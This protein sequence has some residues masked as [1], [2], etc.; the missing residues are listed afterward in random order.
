[1]QPLYQR[2]PPNI[3]DA[4]VSWIAPATQNASLQILFKRPTSAIVFATA[5]KPSRFAYLRQGAESIGLATETTLE[6]PKVVRTYGT[7]SFFTSKCAAPPQR[8]ACFRHLNFQ[9]RSERLVFQH[10]AFKICF[11]PQPRALFRHLNFQKW[12]KHVVFLAPTAKSTPILKCFY[13]FDIEMCFAPQPRALL[14]HRKFQRCPWRWSVFA[15]FTLECVSCCSR[16][17]FSHIPTSKHGLRSVFLSILTSTCASRHSG[18][19][20]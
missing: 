8:R 6:Q 17:R 10:F 13:H 18:A 16:V 1:M 9:K 7:F 20:F 14:A 12:F 11:A 4:H 15:V 2:W 3:S 5:T 19:Q